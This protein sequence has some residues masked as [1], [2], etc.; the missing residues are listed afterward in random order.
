[1]LLIIFSDLPN[2]PDDFTYRYH[3]YTPSSSTCVRTYERANYFQW[4]NYYFC[5]RAGRRDINMKWS[6][7][8]PIKNMKCVLTNEPREP[9]RNGWYNNYLC[10]PKSSP[11]K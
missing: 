1:M 7:N 10:V 2:W 3:S 11:Y 5:S 4:T 6:D 9:R 8:G